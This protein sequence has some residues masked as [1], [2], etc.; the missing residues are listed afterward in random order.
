VL[1]YDRLGQ[2]VWARPELRAWVWE[3]G[4]WET[5]GQAAYG[6][7]AG[8]AGG[9][10]GGAAF[11]GAA[12]AKPSSGRVP[13][14]VIVIIAAVVALI[15]I[16][17]VIGAIALP[18]LL[19]TTESIAKDVMVRAGAET[20]HTGIEAYA[21]DHGGR[22]PPAGEVNAIGLSGYISVWPQNPYT[23]APMADGGGEGNYRY[24]L[25]PDGGAYKLTAYGRDGKVL[26]AITGGTDSSV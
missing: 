1:D 12:G 17:A 9:A 16:G 2:L 24:D 13:A 15:V 11:V 23:S 6:A 18:A 21:L 5:G 8:A 7:A 4:R 20:I 26:L 3:V 22:Y 25:S 19:R 14:W 10:H